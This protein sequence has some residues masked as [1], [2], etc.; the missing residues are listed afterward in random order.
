[1]REE[2]TPIFRRGCALLPLGTIQGSYALE[3]RLKRRV[4]VHY[5]TIKDCDNKSQENLVCMNG[6]NGQIGI[7]HFQSFALKRSSWRHDITD[8]VSVCLSV[9]TKTVKLITN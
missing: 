8:R 5:T 6:I 9:H 2:D 7:S 3:Y 1:M 4:K